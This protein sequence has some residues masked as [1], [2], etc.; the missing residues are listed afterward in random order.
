MQKRLPR[1]LVRTDRTFERD[2]NLKLL[3]IRTYSFW[4]RTDRTFER[5]ENACTGEHFANYWRCEL[6]GLL[7]GM[8]TQIKTLAHQ[9]L[10]LVR[11]D[12]TFERDENSPFSSS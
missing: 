3:L 9:S 4:V 1:C 10:L 11:T 6:T 2:E 5:D 12:R 7:N 8:K